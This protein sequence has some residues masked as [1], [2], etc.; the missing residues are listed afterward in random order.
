MADIS[1]RG[2]DDG[3][4]QKLR[5]RAA[6]HGRSMEAEVRA[7]I[8]MAVADEQPRRDLFD[9]LLDRFDDLGGVHLEL[10]AREPIRDRLDFN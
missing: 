3:V 1:I 2:L 6:A 5:R 8:T 10:P 9:V 7:I 4:K